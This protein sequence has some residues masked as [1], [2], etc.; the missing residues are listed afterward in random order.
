MRLDLSIVGKN[1]QEILKRLRILQ[2]SFESQPVELIDTNCAG[3][4]SDYAFQDTN[5]LWEKNPK[6]IKNDSSMA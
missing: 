5:D 2:N 4:H 1:K 6:G 3:S